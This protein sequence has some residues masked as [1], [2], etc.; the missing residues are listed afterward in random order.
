MFQFDFS[1]EYYEYQ[2]EV[3]YPSFTRMM[4]TPPNQ[5]NKTILLLFPNPVEN[6]LNVSIE[7]K[8]GEMATCEFYNVSGVL[9]HSDELRFRRYSTDLSHLQTGVYMVRILMPDGS[10]RLGKIVKN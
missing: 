4:Q 3:P 1:R 8:D 10:V 9:V 5:Q 2:E 6:T 7:L